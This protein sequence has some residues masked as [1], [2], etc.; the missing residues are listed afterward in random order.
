MT[1]TIAPAD[2]QN[3]QDSD[4][5]R[6]TSSLHED[7]R[8][9][10]M[11]VKKHRLKAKKK[12]LIY[13]DHSGLIWDEWENHKM[14]CVLTLRSQQ[15]VSV[16]PWTVIND[17][18]KSFSKAHGSGKIVSKIKVGEDEVLNLCAARHEC[19]RRGALCF[20][21]NKSKEMKRK[22]FLIRFWGKVDRIIKTS[23]QDECYV[24]MDSENTKFKVPIIPTNQKHNF[25][26]HKDV[27]YMNELKTKNYI[28]VKI[29]AKR[30]EDFRKRFRGHYIPHF[31]LLQLLLVHKDDL[32]RLKKKNHVCRMISYSI[33]HGGWIIGLGDD[34]NIFHP[35]FCSC[36]P[37][38][39]ENTKKKK[40]S[41]FSSE[42]E[43]D[44]SAPCF[45]LDQEPN[46]LYTDTLLK[47][48]ML[49][50]HHV[51]KAYD[52]KN[53]CCYDDDSVRVETYWRKAS[54]QKK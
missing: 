32:S 43:F 2:Q 3:L 27:G 49:G 31:T 40:K 35:F 14:E 38:K 7:R 12:Y 11:V 29:H 48:I 18:W 23:N 30:D 39:V 50:R 15:T 54:R 28:S 41:L 51:W 19:A 37:L 26:F 20:T 34:Y 44:D 4:F 5:F 10:T 45:P 16:K 8:R 47:Q 6:V 21:Y 42:L 22:T 25:T 53:S 1:L 52:F 46:F 17:V 36:S 9:L 13:V 33:P 24:L